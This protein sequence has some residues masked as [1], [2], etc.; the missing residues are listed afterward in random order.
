MAFTLGWHGGVITAAA[1]R[2]GTAQ[3]VR[4]VLRPSMVKVAR[5]A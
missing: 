5:N 1:I 4:R 2:A 3:T